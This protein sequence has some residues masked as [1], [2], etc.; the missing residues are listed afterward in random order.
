MI[1]PALSTGILMATLK[2]TMKNPSLSTTGATARFFRGEKHESL[3]GLR[4][5]LAQL[6]CGA[7]PTGGAT[8]SLYLD[9]SSTAASATVTCAS[10]S[11]GDT[12]T[13]GNIVFTA[14]SGTPSG[15]QFKV[16]VSDTA[17]AASLVSAINA[18]TTLNPHLSAASA[19]GVVTITSKDKGTLGNLFQLTSSNNTRLAVV[20]FASG[21]DATVTSYT[22]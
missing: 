18:N 1:R 2:L 4:N 5:Y 7:A 17:D 9:D 22:F 6:E 10:A 3:N 19:L 13:L 15:N 11:A 12:V 16:G 21:A 8:F 20:G 14:V